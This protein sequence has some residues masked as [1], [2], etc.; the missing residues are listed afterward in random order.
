MTAIEGT[1]VVNEV[2]ANAVQGRE[3]GAIAAVLDH[4]VEIVSVI[5]G[6]TL[7]RDL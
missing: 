5:V 4:G 2:D 3:I 7:G 6:D 1:Q